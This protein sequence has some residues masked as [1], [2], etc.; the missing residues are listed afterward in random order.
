M[1]LTRRKFLALSGLGGAL[2]LLPEDARGLELL[3]PIKVDNPLA[4]Y[5]ARD[6]ETVYRDIWRYDSR[7]V[8]LCAPND[9]HNCL[10]EAYV[11]NGVIVRIEPT[12]GYGKATDV[13]GN[14]VTHRWEPRCCQKGLT[15]MRRFYGDRRVKAPMVRR[16]LLRWVEQGFPREADGR[17]PREF[18][19]RG[20]DEWVR[21]SWDQALDV[22]ARALVDIVRTYSGEAGQARLR[23]QGYDPAMVAATQGAGTQTVKVRGG[24]P[25]LG[26]TRIYAY[27]R[28]GN[29]LALLD[30]WVRQVGPDRAL[31]ARGWDNYSWH[32]DLPPGHPMVTGQQTVDFDLSAAE[33]A[34]LIV[35]WGMNWIATKMPD[36]HWL[37]EA[38]LKGTKVV[39]V[40]VEYSATAPKADEVIVIRPGTDP[41]LALGLAQVLIAEGRYDADFVRR[42]TDLPFLVRLDTLQLLRAAEVFPG[43]EP[44]ELTNF[45]AVLRPGQA[46]P[47]PPLQDRQ[48]VPEALR[49]EWGDF[50]VWDARSGGPQ[51]VS[52]DQVGVHWD[53]LGLDP[54]L[55]GEFTVTTA[56]GRAV[57]VA[58]V[59]A[60]IRRYLDENFTPAQTAEIT[61]APAEAIV[62][63][64]RAIAE[65]RG[66]TLIPV[67][68]GP[69]QFFNS[70]LKDR[71]IFLV[72]ALTANVGQKG[73]NV[74]SYAGNYRAAL[75]NGLPQYIGE[76]PFDIELDPA[77]PARVRVYWK[78]ESAHYYDAGDRPLRVG[79][80]LFTGQTHMPA[81]TKAVFVANSNSILGNAKG[82]YDVIANTLPR[83]ELWATSE[84]WWTMTC[85]YSDIVFPVDAWH[86]LKFPDMCASVT[87][88]FLTVF[89]RTPH[90]RLLD[91]R[92]DLEV[93]AGISARL[94]AITGDRRFLEYWRFVHEGRVEVYLDRILAASNA[95]RG[96][97]F[98]DLER[99]ARDGI[100][101]LMMT[102]TTPRQTGWEQTQESRPWYTKSG[103]LE[104]YREEEEF[105]ALGENLVVY[106]EPVEATFYQ[107]S[108]IVARPHPAIRP[109]PPDRFG[110][111]PADYGRSDVRQVLTLVLPWEDLRKTPSPLVAAG[112]PLIFHTPKYRHG[113]HTTGPDTDFLAVVFG[114]F[115][116]V[117]RRD[118]RTP[119]LAEGYADINP[120]DARARGIEDGDYVWVDG[121]AEDRPYRGWRA[122]DPMYRVA[123][124]MC[125]ARYYPG[126]PRGVVRMWFNMYGA[127]H[128]SVR[129]HES[130]PDGLAKNPATHYQ[131]MFRYGSHQSV[132]R[133]WLRP[134]LSTDSLVRKELFGQLL[135]RGFLADVHTVI[136]APRE[137]MARITK[138]EDGGIGGRGLWHPAAQGFRP[139]YETPALRRYLA[140][141][142]VQV[143]G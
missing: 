115:S 139:T 11:R 107:P 88:P 32:T 67:G 14:R 51:P 116:D 8:F 15:M 132:T 45:T 57:R 78:G 111:A 105:R 58:P 22:A 121:W 96:Y 7:F 37:T 10:L 84:W 127:S 1:E 72:A 2:A 46:P 83:I 63:L 55:E 122:G 71:A 106:K 99:Q 120:A 90:P 118:R 141:A 133:A 110:I 30:A 44:A 69:N 76:N 109:L 53:R 9:T 56:D 12:Y 20:T 23:Q 103:R 36:S 29:A 68:M 18:F 66:R 114:P 65:H 85:E 61:W 125:R 42:F 80:R 50:V 79:T 138:A 126:T 142:Y 28:F 91:T 119:F 35:V 6:W 124:M 70:D 143:R 73:G 41:A 38:R 43:R 62:G 16:G 74:G 128:G 102:R 104:F 64:A 77:K 5:P 137:S 3:E 25:L 123:R 131:A 112:Y 47:A 60:L 113:A 100:P 34:G 48:L 27:Y 21:V 75:F 13:Y 26:A 4:A 54:A 31:G 101:A 117:Y 129:A 134:T 135:G 82:A 130:R 52:R 98:E 86:E 33:H 81:P 40:S 17:P 39:V 136:G 97:R 94:A 89:P 87:N 93:P 140:G 59:F 49:R 108:V 24:M 92:S 19:Q 95:T